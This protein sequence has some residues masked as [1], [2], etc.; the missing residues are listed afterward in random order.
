V[1]L[2]LHAAGYLLRVAL[3]VVVW[4]STEL[5]YS[6]LPRALAIGTLDPDAVRWIAETWL[7][8]QE[9]AALTGIVGLVAAWPIAA[10]GTLLALA[11]DTIF[12]ATVRHAFS[13]FEPGFPW[14]AIGVNLT[15]GAVLALST[16][17]TSGAVGPLPAVG[18]ERVAAVG[19]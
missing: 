1:Q 17:A 14:L 3:G 2:V 7:R 19:E 10:R 4:M 15:I 8:A 6:E 16:R 9:A 12:T 18:A 5:M 13:G 11:M